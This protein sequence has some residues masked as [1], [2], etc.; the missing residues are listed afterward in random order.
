MQ[1][2]LQ[3]FLYKHHHNNPINNSINARLD[4]NQ[5]GNLD[6]NRGG[7]LDNNREGEIQVGNV[8]DDNGG[9]LGDDKK[10]GRITQIQDGGHDNDGDDNGGGLGAPSHPFG[11]IFR[12][13][14]SDEE[15]WLREK[16][17][18]EMLQGPWVGQGLGYGQDEG[19]G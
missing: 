19:E 17:R 14:E 15:V 3:L 10:T 4:D 6:D 18:V 5:V 9:G 16:A 12:A 8:G 2:R 11:V 7:K 13:G 1:Q